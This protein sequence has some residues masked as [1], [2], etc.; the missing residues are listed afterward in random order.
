MIKI[1]LLPRTINEKAAIRN[2]AMIFAVLFVAVIAGGITYASRVSAQAAAEEQL[3]DATVQLETIVKGIQAEEAGW[4]TKT[5]PVQ[6][7][8]DFINSVLKFNNVYPDLFERVARWTYENVQ[9]TSLSC[10][11]TVVTL[12]ARAKSLD[13]IG[14]FL[15]NMYRATDLFTQVGISGVP[16]Y[17]QSGQNGGG[18]SYDGGGSTDGSQ[19]NLAGINAINS[20]VDKGPGQSWIDFTV[21]CTLKQPI[22]IP[23]FAGA[24]APVDPNA[25]PGAAAPVAPAPVAPPPGQ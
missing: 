23:A 15:L 21:T 1:N 24:A 16:G 8:L 2:T 4:K 19:G 5:T 10:D 12:N 9:Y 22:A 14:R 17:G 18:P 20:G 7:K 6:Q 3:A 11:G 13:D 25:V